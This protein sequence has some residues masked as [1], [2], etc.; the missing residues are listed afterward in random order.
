VSQKVPY[1]KVARIS[2]RD[3][4]STNILYTQLVGV[5]AWE[6]DTTIRNWSNE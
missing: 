6:G 2:P 4:G 3:V 1:T 5:L